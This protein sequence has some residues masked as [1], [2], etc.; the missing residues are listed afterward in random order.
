MTEIILPN[1]GWQPRPH[2]RNAW[3]ALQDGYKRAVLNWHRRAG[4]DDICLHWTATQAMQ[5]PASYWHMLPQFNQGRRAIWEAVNPHTGLR[6]IDEA[7]PPEIRA[8]TDSQSMTIE[9]INGA[10][11]HVVGS[12][13]YNALVGSPPAGVVF[14]EWSLADPAAWPYIRPILDENGGWAIFIYTSRG[15]NHGWSI[16]QHAKHT[17]GWYAESIPATETA[18]FSPEQ[19]KEAKRELIELYGEGPGSALYRQEYLCDFD[20]AVL[21]AYYSKLMQDAESEGRIGDIPYDPTLPV[22]TWWDL[23]MHDATSIVFAQREKGTPWV[24]VIDYHESSGEGLPHYAKV[25]QDKGYTYSRHVM[26]HDVK[27]REL[28]SGKSRLEIAQG[29]GMKVDIAPQQKVE[30]GIQAVRALLPKCRFDRVKTKRL[31]EALRSY[32]TEYDTERRV[33]KPKPVHDWTSHPADAFRYG[34]VSRAP[35]AARPPQL[36]P[37]AD[38]PHYHSESWMA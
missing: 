15:R 37:W 27:V 11:W 4:K 38:Q 21:G 5:R 23:G 29:L 35:A 6:R 18:V 31:V 13:N 26:P 10:M 2:Q 3:Q 24:N 8:R 1:N 19:L 34:A 7:F 36:D 17:E 32:R 14:S 25:L 22:E 20:A 9:F 16:L 30:D 28:G 33:F 12:D